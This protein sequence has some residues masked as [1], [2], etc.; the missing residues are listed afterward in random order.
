MTTFGAMESTLTAKSTTFAAAIM[1]SM[2]KYGLL[3]TIVLDKDSKFVSVFRKTV[4][5]HDTMRVK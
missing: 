5:N 1:K 2:L 3:H 4:N